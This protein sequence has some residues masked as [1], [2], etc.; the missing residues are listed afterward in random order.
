M[1]T[2]KERSLEWKLWELKSLENTFEFSV[3]D[4]IL[5]SPGGGGVLDLSL[6]G[7]VP[8]DLETLTLFLIKRS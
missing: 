3:A 8:P 7:G 6:G 5:S 4:Y 1:N 2:R